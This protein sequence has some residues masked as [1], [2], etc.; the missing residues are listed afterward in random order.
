MC[1]LH[2]LPRKPVDFSDLE[3]EAYWNAE[4]QRKEREEDETVAEYKMRRDSELARQVTGGQDQSRSAT[5]RFKCGG[6]GG[7]GYITIYR[8]G[9]GWGQRGER[10]RCWKGCNGTGYTK[11]DPNTLRLQRQ[12]RE[13][14][15]REKQIARRQ[16]AA[17]F[18]EANPDIAGWF[19]R[20]LSQPQ[21]WE[22]AVSFAQQLSEKGFLS[23]KQIGVIRNSIA[24]QAAKDAERQAKWAADKPTTGLDLGNVPDGMYAV[25]GGDTRLKVRIA[26][27]KKAGKWAGVIFVDDGAVYG[28]RQ[29]YGRQLVGQTYRGAIQEELRKIAADPRAAMAAYGHLVGRCGRCGRP[30]EDEVS[31]AQG[32]GPVCI[33]KMG[34]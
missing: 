28:Q 25:P 1:Q 16:E 30:L 7:S 19:D 15:K 2:D 31:V 9:L 33:Q 34:W 17:A 27:G 8:R 29:N 10:K 23:E 3:D 13:E 14:I 21:P 32:I 22:L 18:R 20:E 26:R 12:R 24:R 6:C 5:R 11:T 4:M